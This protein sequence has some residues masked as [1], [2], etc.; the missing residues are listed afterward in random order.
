MALRALILALFAAGGA[1]ASE[2]ILPFVA[3]RNF[4]SVRRILRL[5][6]QF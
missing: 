5:T 3:C 6:C 1:A 4:D 2:C